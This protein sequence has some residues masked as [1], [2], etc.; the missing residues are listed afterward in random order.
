M[1]RLRWFVGVRFSQLG[2]LVNFRQQ[3]Q[4]RRFRHM[5]GK[6]EHAGESAG[7]QRCHQ[8][9]AKHLDFRSVTG[10]AEGVADVMSG[11]MNCR[12]MSKS[13]AENHEHAEYQS[14][15]SRQLSRGV[16][17]RC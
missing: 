13:R 8:E 15:N 16:S 7:D 4:R 10:E 1:G 3:D 6:H 11:V 2:V 5:A 17:R 12:Q 9:P 14:Q